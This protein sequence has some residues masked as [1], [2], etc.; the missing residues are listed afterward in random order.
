[1]KGL[2]VVIL[3][4]LLSCCFRLSAQQQYEFR[5]RND[6]KIVIDSD[7]VKDP[8]AGGLNSPVFSKI[9]LNNDGTEDLFIYDRTLNKIFTYVA[10]TRNGQWEWQYAPQYERLFPR[11][12]TDWVLLRDYNRDGRKDIFTKTNA[13]IKVYKNTTA[14]NGIPAFTQAV[15]FIRFNNNIN[16]QAGSENLPALLDMDDDGDLDILTFDFSG[17]TTVEYY[18]NLAVEEKL[19]ADDLKYTLETNWWGKLTKCPH[20]CNGYLFNS[21]C[22]T[23][24][25]NHNDGMNL[26]ALD[27]DGDTDKDI[28]VG[29]EACPDL[30][31]ITNSGTLTNAVLASSGLQLNYPANTTRAS[32][33]YFPAAYYEDVN[34]DNRPDLLVAPFVRSNTNDQVNFTQSA[35]LYKNTSATQ[36]PAFELQQKNFLQ[37]NM[38]D[39]GEQSV[40]ALA[41][42]DGDGDLDL[43]LGNRTGSVW[44]FRNVGTAA[45]AIFK[46]ETRD[47]LNLAGAGFRDIKPQ[48]AD[49]NSDGRLDL[50]LTVATGTTG[51]IKY[52]L[53][54]AGAG[55][56]FNY[57]LTNI[58]TLPVGQ[59]ISDVPAFY[60]LDNDG[61]L[62]LVLASNVRP[63]PTSGALRF[64]RNT[65]TAANPNFTLENEAWGNIAAELARQNVYPIITDLNKDRSPEL[66]LVD[67]FG[68]IRIFG[69]IRQNLNNTFTPV[70]QILQNPLTGEFGPSKLGNFL[71]LAAG[72]LNADGMPELI[73][74]TRAG[75]LHYLSQ[76][77][78]GA[79]VDP[80]PL[81]EQTQVVIYPNPI[82]R[83]LI[84]TIQSPEQV[85]F[86]LYNLAGQRIN[87]GG[88]Q[89]MA[90]IHRVPVAG[91]A[92]GL[93]LVQVITADL[94]RKAYKVVVL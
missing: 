85:N 19:P 59:A 52:I 94:R 48:F 39:A 27:L 89:E 4:F 75:G 8:W 51:A 3:F 58:K 25:T 84:L 80:E 7:T 50:M 13:G 60:D 24:G 5:Y 82:K 29:G 61:D 74:G 65:G 68:E 20:V 36:V 78:R 38:V 31:R 87:I 40:P 77:M 21:S 91:L 45:K 86:V 42:L 81:P 44:L 63:T 11:D 43:L 26:L 83:D 55:Q 66:L 72:D 90:K 2:P 17:S 70:N 46:L 56:P 54:T 53:N 32:F 69:N 30:V 93:Y 23:D 33:N 18:K 73:I 34:F 6:V 37:A 28:L 10:V 15:D 9:E 14:A 47:Y 16:L 1:M 41:D 35:W 88:Y 92:P 57:A 79:I 71:A 49:M 22:R 62:D 64:Y 76:Q 12:L 67:D